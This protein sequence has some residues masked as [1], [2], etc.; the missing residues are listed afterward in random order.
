[1]KILFFVCF[2]NRFVY[3]NAKYFIDNDTD[4]LIGHQ[5]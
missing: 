5:L 4:L 3:E 1:M 2:E